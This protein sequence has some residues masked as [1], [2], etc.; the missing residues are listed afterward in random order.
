MLSRLKN[1]AD[2]L[3]VLFAQATIVKINSQ[4]NVSIHF[5]H[6]RSE[7]HLSFIRNRNKNGILISVSFEKGFKRFFV[8]SDKFDALEDS[9]YKT[10]LY[11]GMLFSAV[12]PGHLIVFL[13]QFANPLNNFIKLS[14]GKC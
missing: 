10:C 13:S 6:C 14:Y 11:D 1:L 2:S 4:S 5:L 12:D 7:I 8:D 9:A 3:C